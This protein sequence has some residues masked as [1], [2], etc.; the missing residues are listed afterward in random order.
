VVTCLQLLVLRDGIQL[1][2]DAA[3]ALS[4]PSSRLRLP[5][6]L[7]SM[8]RIPPAFVQARKTQ[9]EEG[10]S[11]WWQLAQSPVAWFLSKPRDV[12]DV[13]WR[14]FRGGLPHLAAAMAVFVVLSRLARLRSTRLRMLNN[15]MA[16]I[17][18]I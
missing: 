11:L 12:S 7:T 3:A 6:R 16:S 17:L 4:M 14:D 10:A 8:L 5:A 2:Q 15:M 18:F 13:Q 1:S 9:A